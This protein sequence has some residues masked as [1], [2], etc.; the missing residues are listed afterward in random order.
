MLV[1]SSVA[2]ALIVAP[3]KLPAA[4]AVCGSYRTATAEMVVSA[5]STLAELYIY[6]WLRSGSGGVWWLRWQ[7]LA[8][9]VSRFS[10]SP[11]QPAAL[12]TAG[13]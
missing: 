3:V 2:T 10:L 7:F 4:S 12:A 9:F 13:L 11:L 8:V 5:K 1:L 6:Y